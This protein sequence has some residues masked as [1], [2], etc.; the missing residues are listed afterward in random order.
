[1][2]LKFKCKNCFYNKYDKLFSLGSLNYSGKFPKKKSINV[3]QNQINL[4]KCKKC[5]LVQLDRKFNPKYL[6]NLDY[7]YRSGINTTMKNHLSNISTKLSKLTNLNQNDHVLDIA[8]NDGTLLNSYKKKNIV[9]VGIDPILN[10]FIR[11]YNNIDYKINSFFNIK[12]IKSKGIKNKFK[13]I[14]AC[15]VFYDVDKPNIFLKDISNLLDQKNGIF[16]LE[17]QDLYSIIKYNLF[18]TICHEHLEYYSLSVI[19]TM[20]KKNNLKLIKVSRN[21]ING[22]SLGLYIS[23]IKSGYKLTKKNLEK[24]L[25]LEKKIKIKELITYKRFFL[26]ILRIKRRV[27]KLISHILKNKKII[28]GYGASTKGNILLQFFNITNEEIKYIADRNPEKVN[29]FT[30]G[31]KIKIISEQNSRKMQPD[32]YLVLPWHFKNEILIREKKIRKKGAKFIFPLPRF[33]IKN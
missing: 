3:P 21:N 33:E 16:Y 7:G 29:L 17:F 18:D 8:S 23:H 32:Y 30:P 28:H 5:H 2:S 26:K 14:T 12:A 20:L 11:F 13:I 6:Y 10:K 22:G 27:K 15:A 24:N 19:L 4:V 25:N 31:T 1:M 9:K